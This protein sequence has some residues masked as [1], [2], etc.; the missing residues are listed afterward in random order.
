MQ[1]SALVS[2]VLTQIAAKV[3]SINGGAVAFDYYR[4]F[5]T[6]CQVAPMHPRSLQAT[7]VLVFHG[8]EVAIQAAVHLG[9]L[10]NRRLVAT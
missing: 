7:T 9:S 8:S 10:T 3:E 1:P 6:H 5:A 2:K 4:A